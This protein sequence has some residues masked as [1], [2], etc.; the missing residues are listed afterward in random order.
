MRSFQPV[1]G[2]VGSESSE[3]LTNTLITDVIN[4][5]I[6]KLDISHVAATAASKPT[7]ALRMSIYYFFFNAL[8]IIALNSHEMSIDQRVEVFYRIQP[9]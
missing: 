4:V 6:S 3:F 7:S 9:A 1:F 8:Q 5:N 2:L